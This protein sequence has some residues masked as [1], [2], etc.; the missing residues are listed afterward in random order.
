MLKAHIEE[1]ETARSRKRE[2]KQE[3]KASLQKSLKD[4]LTWSACVISQHEIAQQ[5]R[6]LPANP[7]SDW[8]ER[9]QR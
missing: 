5:A 3:A 4:L 6:T 1:V 2:R 9:T 7:S 8:L